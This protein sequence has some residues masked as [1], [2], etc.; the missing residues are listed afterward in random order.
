MGWSPR[1][2]SSAGHIM[3]GAG[4]VYPGR[5]CCFVVTCAYSGLDGQAVFKVQVIYPFSKDDK[6]ILR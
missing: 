2:Y 5:I 6:K 1:G 3:E 4:C